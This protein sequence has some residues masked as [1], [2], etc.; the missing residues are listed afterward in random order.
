MFDPT[1]PLIIGSPALLTFSPPISLLEHRLK[2]LLWS[3]PSFL[4]ISTFSLCQE[5]LIPIAFYADLLFRSLV[6]DPWCT[7]A[8]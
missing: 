6:P 7:S 4:C 8:K 1:F 2:E 5:F 3:L